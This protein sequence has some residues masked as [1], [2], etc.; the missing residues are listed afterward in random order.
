MIA[1]SLPFPQRCHGVPRGML[2]TT[3]PGLYLARILRDD[4][5]PARHREPGEAHELLAV[6]AEDHDPQPSPALARSP[7]SAHV[8]GSLRAAIVDLDPDQLARH[9]DDDPE[10][11]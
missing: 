9:Q 3:H 4:D 11:S 10:E 1:P 6:D 8:R 5:R 7:R 2:D